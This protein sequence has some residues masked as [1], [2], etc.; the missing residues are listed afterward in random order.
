ME[1]CDVVVIGAG[2]AG[3]AAAIEAARAGLSVTVLDEQP[4]PGGQIWRAIETTDARRGAIL[5]PDYLVGRGIVDAFRAS[6]ANYRPG[7]LVWNI[8][9]DRTV[10]Y[11]QSGCS[12]RI[13]AGRIVVATGA[14]E[15]PSPVPGWTLPGVSTAGALQILL[16][17]SGVVPDR[18]VIAGS[19]PL[20]WLIAAQM[21]AAGV[22][23]R[24]VVETTP[25]GRSLAAL[26]HPGA[27]LRGGNYLLK[28]M[29]LLA[30]VRLAGVPVFS[31][32][33]DLVIEGRDAVSAIR[34]NC[35]GKSRRIETDSVAL[36]Q[37]VVPN[38][39]VSRLL[40]CAHFWDASQMCFRP[41]LDANYESSVEGVYIVGDGAGISGARSAL[42]Q[43]RLVGHVIAGCAGQVGEPTACGK[44]RRQIAQ[45]T[46]VRPFLE[47][48]YA[49][50]PEILAPAD[51]TLVCRCEEITAG[52]IRAAVDTGGVA[53]PN[54]VK[55]M[56]RTGMG[57]CQ[58]RVCGLAVM[59]I[60]SA[61][62]GVPPDVTDYY[63]IR[64][65]L[66]PLTI[67]ELAAPDTTDDNR[68]AA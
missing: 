55:A 13:A 14:L 40:R 4:R 54:Q 29:L 36:H 22:A 24:A 15:R 5:G 61:R 68:P 16:K 11:S 31:H 23:P 53:G 34:F 49:P 67:G 18:A 66:K 62:R 46:A 7:A 63:R 30:K 33:R 58:G 41:K 37:G 19:G 2:P 44:I 48:L 51:G 28:G 1:Q 8:S 27:V 3:M 52:Q 32:A 57:P 47:S 10:D 26:R 42:L 6:G 60:I 25:L 12:H 56:L 59:A 39:Q 64:P 43:G 35:H 45:D 38:Q 9:R 21:V 50:A 17:S 65:P 20:I